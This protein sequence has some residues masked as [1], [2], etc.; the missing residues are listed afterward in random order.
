MSEKC[1]CVD[2][3][4]NVLVEIVIVAVDYLT[5]KS[6]YSVFDLTGDLFVATL[7]DDIR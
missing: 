3:L 2:S 7:S 4:N 1:T 6:T 5:L